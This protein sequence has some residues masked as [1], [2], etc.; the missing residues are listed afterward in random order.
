MAL[1]S[2]RGR[3]EP[4]EPVAPTAGA[5][6][7]A[8]APV[9]EEAASAAVVEEAASAAVVEDVASAPDV[10]EEAVPQVGISVSAFGA[11]PPPRRPAETAPPAP[12]PRA[13]SASPRRARPAGS[14]GWRSSPT[15]S[16]SSHSGAATGR[17]R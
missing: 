17:F 11:P 6:Q 4:G 3:A 7:A 9:V 5:Q 16:R 13:A 12:T 8:S 1:F 15:R 2:R 10:V 14:A